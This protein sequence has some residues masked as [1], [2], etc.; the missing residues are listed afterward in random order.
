MV[1]N[2]RK[3]DRSHVLTDVNPKFTTWENYHVFCQNV[4]VSMCQLQRGRKGNQAN[5][6][7]AQV[8]ILQ[9]TAWLEKW[10]QLPHF[11]NASKLEGSNLLTSAGQEFIYL[12]RNGGKYFLTHLP[13]T[14][15]ILEK[16]SGHPRSWTFFARLRVPPS[17]S[18]TPPSHPS[19]LH[20][21]N[22]YTLFSWFSASDLA[23]VIV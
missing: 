7:N 9:V 19:I 3:K 16:G 17:S 1:A 23:N 12:S 21:W 13:R 14:Q 10:C 2:M 11:R 4:N 18:N 20:H 15:L 5:L 22:V 8:L 6:S